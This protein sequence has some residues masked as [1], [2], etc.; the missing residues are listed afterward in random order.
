MAPRSL[1]RHI[2]RHSLYA[3]AHNAPTPPKAS[4]DVPNHL[5]KTLKRAASQRHL[6]SPDPIPDSA[7]AYKIRLESRQSSVLEDI[8]EESEDLDDKAS[9]HS[10]EADYTTHSESDSDIDKTS[11][12]DTLAAL[13]LSLENFT[14]RNLIMAALNEARIATYAHLD[15]IETS[16]ALLEVLEGLSATIAVLEEEMLEKRD[17]CKEKLH[18]LEDVERV[19]VRMVFSGES[20]GEV[21]Q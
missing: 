7:L 12:A 18:M 1:L 16:L 4:A 14:T 9:Y 5:S 17:K 11:V 8:A 10:S 13:Q 20:R 6:V 15:T 3:K 19:V 2:F 21:E